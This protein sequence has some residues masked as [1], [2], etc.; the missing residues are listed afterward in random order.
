MIVYNDAGWWVSVLPE[1]PTIDPSGIDG[2]M[3]MGRA[4]AVC[5]TYKSR[6][7]IVQERGCI[8]KHSIH[9][10]TKMVVKIFL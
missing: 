2:V 5:M 1:T 10:R 6:V 8:R 7:Y 4:Y 9:S 3:N